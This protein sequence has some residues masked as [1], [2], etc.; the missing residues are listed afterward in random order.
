MPL[1]GV[2]PMDCTQGLGGGQVG[3]YD[4]N[5]HVCQVVVPVDK[6]VACVVKHVK[7]LPN[8]TGNLKACLP[9]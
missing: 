3:Y 1:C 5:L 2:L 4:G 8:A 9:L 7:S 6:T